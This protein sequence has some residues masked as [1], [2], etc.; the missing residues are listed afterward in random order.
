MPSAW[1][2]VRAAR[3]RSAFTGD[4]GR[5]YGGRWNS[6]GTAIVYA[7]EHESL[8]ALELF[9]HVQPLSPTERY[10]SFRLELEDKL[11][12]YLPVKDLPPGW[13]VEPPT[14]ETMQIG[15]EW[16]L[17]GRSLA[18]AVPS[19]LST[20]E[21]NFLLNPNHLGFK[22]IKISRPVEYRF[23]PRLLGR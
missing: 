7:S 23:D 9:V 1:R 15:D 20:S 5:F 19:V 21:M 2:I 10:F 8:A 16:I 12:E 17:S 6:R 4:G 13:N 11:T 22:K 3:V 18:L 14:I